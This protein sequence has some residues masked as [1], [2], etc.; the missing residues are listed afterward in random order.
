MSNVIHDH[1]SRGLNFPPLW[2]CPVWSSFTYIYRT[3]KAPM[4]SFT[5][6]A[7]FSLHLTSCCIFWLWTGET[8]SLFQVWGNKTGETTHQKLGTQCIQVESDSKNSHQICPVST[9]W[10]T[11]PTRIKMGQRHR[12]CYRSGQGW[13]LH[14]HLSFPFSPPRFIS[15]PHCNTQY[16]W[17]S[18]RLPTQQSVELPVLVFLLHLHRNSPPSRL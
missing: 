12:L 14:Q 7:V 17:T 11:R 15:W 8:H 3:H 1:V 13:A 5:G 10:H 16:N 18:V 4:P 9:L 6:I 2:R